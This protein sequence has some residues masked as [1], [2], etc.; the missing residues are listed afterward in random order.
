MRRRSDGDVIMLHCGHSFFAPCEHS[1]AIALLCVYVYISLYKGDRCI[2]I[3]EQ[4]HEHLILVLLVFLFSFELLE[5]MIICQN[6]FYKEWN[7]IST[8][9]VGIYFQS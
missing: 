3:L 5:T 2:L 1:R 8:I 7:G 4:G 6:E 9:N